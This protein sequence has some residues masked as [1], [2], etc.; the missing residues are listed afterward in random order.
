MSYL[1]KIEMSFSNS[2]LKELFRGIAWFIDDPK[3]L[4]N[5]ALAHQ[6]SAIAVKEFTPYKKKQFL[7]NML[8][9]TPSGFSRRYDILPNGDVHGDVHYGHSTKTYNSGVFICGTTYNI[10]AQTINRYYKKTRKEEE[11]LY[12]TKHFIVREISDE[13]RNFTDIHHIKTGRR[14]HFYN[15]P[16]CKWYHFAEFWDYN[17]ETNTRIFYYMFSD[18]D[19]KTRNIRLRYLRTVQCRDFHYKVTKRLRIASKIIE[20]AKKQKQKLSLVKII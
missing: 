3:T 18:C 2:M 13:I 14:V 17:Y 6:F 11:K 9:S 20:Y 8:I 4:M 1:K 12:L 5:F 16:L 19:D 7:T 15:C 10:E